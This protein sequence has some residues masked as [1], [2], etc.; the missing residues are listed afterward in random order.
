GERSTV[1]DMLRQRPELVHMD[2][3]ANNE[4]RALHFAVLHRR[5]EMVRLLM[6]H[7]A[8]ARKGIYPHRDATSALQIARD[9]GDDEIVAIIEAEEQARREAMSCPNIT[10]T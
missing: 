2:L 9:R 8:D 5:P 1:R 4:H 10:V 3:A 6:H 7:G